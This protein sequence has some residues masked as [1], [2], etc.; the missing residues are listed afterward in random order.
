MQIR[1]A[2]AADAPAACHPLRRSIADLSSADHHDDPEIKHL[3][4]APRVQTALEPGPRRRP[5]RANPSNPAATSA[6]I[7][8][9]SA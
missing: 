7:T 3:S 4:R 1:D 9:A 2:V 8:V 5:T 6:T